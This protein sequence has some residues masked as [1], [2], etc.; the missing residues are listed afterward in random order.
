MGGVP[1]YTQVPLETLLTREYTTANDTMRELIYEMWALPRKSLA[2]DNPVRLSF[3]L[4]ESHLNCDK[5]WEDVSRRA[6]A[7]FKIETE[8]VVCASFY[9]FFSY[10]QDPIFAVLCQV[11]RVDDWHSTT[12]PFGRS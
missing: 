9:N 2:E 8:S 11:L 3:Y 4:V 12:N 6:Y 5:L 7:N 10:Q 1:E